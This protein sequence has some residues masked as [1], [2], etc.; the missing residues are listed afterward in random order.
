[1]KTD[2][3]QI[4]DV[5][6]AEGYYA[7]GLALRIPSAVIYA[8]DTDQGALT[9]C[10]RMARLNGVESRL[11]TRSF[12]SPHPL[13]SIPLTGRGLII[14]DCEGYEKELFGPETP[15][16]LEGCDLLIEIHD[17]VDINISSVLRNRFEPTHDIEVV[18][19]LDDI[20]K[21]KTY[22]YPEINGYGL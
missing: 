17:F 11:I 4:I 20:Q 14:C 22:D 2:Y 5:G 12:C 15:R 10:E 7:V 21:A 9:L 18:Q 19:S 3:H 16:R 1:C 13:P 6:C 8:F